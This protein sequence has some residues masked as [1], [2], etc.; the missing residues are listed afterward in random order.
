MNPPT[1]LQAS[2]KF[3]TQKPYDDVISV[4]NK[5]KQKTSHSR[6]F[7]HMLPLQHVYYEYVLIYKVLSVPTAQMMALT[8]INP[9]RQNTRPRFFCV[10]Q[11]LCA[12]FS[13]YNF[14]RHSALGASNNYFWFWKGRKTLSKRNF[15]FDS[16]NSSC[17]WMENSPVRLCYFLLFYNHEWLA[18]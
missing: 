14:I 12:N 9:F 17:C 15:V 6:T 3:W 7:P 11:W 2:Q 1:P 5:R 4:N 10:W 16:L 13:V 18:V 8:F